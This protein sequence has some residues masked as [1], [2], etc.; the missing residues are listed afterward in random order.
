MFRKITLLLF[1]YVTGIG[2]HSQL[3]CGDPTCEVLLRT[4]SSSATA[5]GYLTL[6][7]GANIWLVITHALTCFCIVIPCES[8]AFVF[9]IA[10]VNGFRTLLNCSC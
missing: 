1:H 5:I 6:L 7:Y 3:S 9:P 2:H 8:G 4:T 10:S